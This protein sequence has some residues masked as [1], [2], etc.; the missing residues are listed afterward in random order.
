MDRDVF[1]VT[2]A[3]VP[4]VGG[5]GAYESMLPKWAAENSRMPKICYDIAGSVAGKYRGSRTVCMYV[6]MYP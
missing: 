5:R 3:Y 2:S 6:Y 1:D 4:Q